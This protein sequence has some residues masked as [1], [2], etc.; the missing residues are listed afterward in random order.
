MV[1]QR[2]VASSATEAK[3]NDAEKDEQGLKRFGLDLFAG[4]PTTFAPISDVPVP[5]DYTVGAGDEIV[6]Q[7]FG[8]E[9]TTHRLR[10]NR[11]G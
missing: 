4:S 5:A 8:K 10:V 3:V 1:E 2:P 7:L 9:N 11:A 6:I